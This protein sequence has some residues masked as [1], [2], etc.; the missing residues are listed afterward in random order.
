MNR[1]SVAG[2]AFASVVRSAALTVTDE[3]GWARSALGTVLGVGT[4]NT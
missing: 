3:S 4:A 2:I 1:T